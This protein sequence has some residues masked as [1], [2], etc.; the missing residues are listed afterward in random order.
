MTGA[1]GA[2]AS[3]VT[4]VSFFSSHNSPTPSPGLTPNSSISSLTTTIPVV[5]PAAQVSTS[6][7]G[8]SS[9]TSAQYMTN[10][11]QNIGDLSTC[12]C[13]LKWFETHVSQS[14][15]AEDMAGLIQSEQDPNSEPPPDLVNAYVACN[16]GGG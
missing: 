3:I 8:S 1:L 15:F 11:A 6:I 9:A 13:T 10:C 2:V 16:Y 5:T 14:R 12:Q 4:I 7:A